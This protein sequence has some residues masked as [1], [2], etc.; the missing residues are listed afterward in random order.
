MLQVICSPVLGT[1][2]R[3]FYMAGSHSTAELCPQ[4]WVDVLGETVVPSYGQHSLPYL[5]S[6]PT[7]KFYVGLVFSGMISTE[8][9]L[10]VIRPTLNIQREPRFFCRRQ[11]QSVIPKNATCQRRHS[12]RWNVPTANI[13]FLNVS[14]SAWS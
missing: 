12:E 10:T 5:F 2:P 9:H 11:R 8:N 13:R 4:C 14:S 1:E 3:T 6:I 7:T